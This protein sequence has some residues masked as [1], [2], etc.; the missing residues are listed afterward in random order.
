MIYLNDVPIN[1]SGDNNHYKAYLRMILETTKST[2]NN[3]LDCAGYFHDIGP[4][5]VCN[6]SY[7][8][9]SNFTNGLLFL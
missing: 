6:F 8:K 1:A 5:I 2:K 3:L 9:V 7:F 4:Q